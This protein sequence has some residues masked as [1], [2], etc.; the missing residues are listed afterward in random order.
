[1]KSALY[2]LLFV[3]LTL[4][5]ISATTSRPKSD[6][7]LLKLQT[8][9]PE[10]WKMQFSTDT[11]YI[12]HDEPIYL[13]VSNY[14]N[15]PAEAFEDS[16]ENMNKIIT[17]GKETRAQIVFYRKLKDELSEEEESKA[18]YFSSLYALFEIN[19]QGFDTPYARCY[20]WKTADEAETIYFTLIQSILKLGTGPVYTD[21]NHK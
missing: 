17:S 10:G 20:P 11:M 7:L 3:G 5:F 21:V 8:S 19:A 9:L 16:D 12:T 15:A 13:L 18:N 14:I 1:M 6:S 2:S 4:I